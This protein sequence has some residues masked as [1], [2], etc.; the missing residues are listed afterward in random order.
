MYIYDIYTEKNGIVTA[1]IFSYNQMKC[2]TCNEEEYIYL[3]FVDSV[4]VILA[5]VGPIGPNFGPVSP[6]IAK[7]KRI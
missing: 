4:I 7:I 5:M 2:L 6:T 1:N 3:L